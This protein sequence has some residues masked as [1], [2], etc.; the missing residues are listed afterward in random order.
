MVKQQKNIIKYEKK[1]GEN[2]WDHAWDAV[3]MTVAKCATLLSQPT[4]P[5]SALA[6]EG[7]KALTQSLEKM[8]I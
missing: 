7:D 2:T 4:Q 1:W 8:E 6:I 5:K 3:D